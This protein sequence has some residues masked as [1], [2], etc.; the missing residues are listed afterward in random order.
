MLRLKN[1]IYFK[2]VHKVQQMRESGTRRFTWI[3]INVT[4]RKRQ[5][6]TTMP[7][8]D[9]GREGCRLTQSVMC[10]YFIFKYK[11]SVLVELQLYPSSDRPKTLIA[12]CMCITLKD[13]NSRN[14]IKTKQYELILPGSSFRSVSEQHTH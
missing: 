10:W 9:G 13:T 11:T 12:D 6:G 5:Y 1:A 4:P 2:L 8:V 7:M 14:Q 3:N